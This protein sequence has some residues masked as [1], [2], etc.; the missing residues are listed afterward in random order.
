MPCCGTSAG[1]RPCIMVKLAD[2]QK[3]AD[4]L[5]TEDKNGLLAHLLHS[6]EGAPTGADDSEVMA[7]D[8]EMES[9]VVTPLSHAEFVARVR[10]EA[11]G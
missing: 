5:S 10:P 1:Y 3:D 9:G 11:A 8:A 7:R 6:L 4:K 2:V